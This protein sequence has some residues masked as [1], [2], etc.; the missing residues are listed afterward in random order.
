MYLIPALLPSFSADDT[1]IIILE[2]YKFLTIELPFFM[3]L[4]MHV[5]FFHT[6][7]HGSTA[8]YF[9][10]A[11][12]FHLW[13]RSHPL[14]LTQR[15]WYRNSI[16]FLTHMQFSLSFILISYKYDVSL[17]ISKKKIDLTLTPTMNLFF[18]FFWDKIS[19]KN[20]AFAV[21]KFLYLS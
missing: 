3:Q 16:S 5:V 14:I 13:I 1:I 11:Q 7:C 18:L 19:H 6:R 12:P 2:V 15:Y 9:K 21:S 17:F 20:I 8:P 4:S 10:Y